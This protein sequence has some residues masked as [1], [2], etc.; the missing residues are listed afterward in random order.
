MNLCKARISKTCPAFVGAKGGGHI[1][2]FGVCRQV[3][4][5]SVTASRHHHG[6]GRVAS[7][8]S[9]FQIPDDDPAGDSVN[10]HDV[11]HLGTG[12]H[13]DR[14]FGDLFLERRVGT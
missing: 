13:R 11:H 6:V 5:V 9:G 7:D 14:F 12:V 1:A 4:D 8:F 10:N 3:E 2:V